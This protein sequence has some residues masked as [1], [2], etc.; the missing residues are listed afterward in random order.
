MTLASR[1]G[2]AALGLAGSIEQPETLRGASASLLW[3]AAQCLVQSKCPPNMYGWVGG[4]EGD[5]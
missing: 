3:S 5:R 1:A 2:G 4:C